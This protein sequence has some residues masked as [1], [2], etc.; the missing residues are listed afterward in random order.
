MN[1]DGPSKESLEEMPEVDFT[2]VK[3]LGRGLK[4]DRRVTLEL[5]REVLGK[6]PG[7]IARAADMSPEHVAQIETGEPVPVSELAQYAKAL[8]GEL[9]VAVTLNGRRYR[10]VV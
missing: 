6:T 1:H 4:K 7:D 8:G 10:I 9:D 3:I 2:K 5:L